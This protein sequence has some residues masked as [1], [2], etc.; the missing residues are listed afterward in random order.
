MKWGK[1]RHKN[2]FDEKRKRLNHSFNTLRF[3]WLEISLLRKIA[4]VKSTKSFWEIKKYLLRLQ[5]NRTSIDRHQLLYQAQ[6]SLHSN[7]DYYYYY[8]Y[9]FKSPL[10]CSSSSLVKRI[11]L[12]FLGIAILYLDP[13]VFVFGSFR[14]RQISVHN[15]SI[16]C[17]IETQ[18][19]IGYFSFLIFVHF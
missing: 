19:F 5:S 8:Y 13:I 2:M 15:I 7:I 18:C 17:I 12:K 14:F 10:K 6:N 16:D 1:V 3:V 11:N 9:C 4:T